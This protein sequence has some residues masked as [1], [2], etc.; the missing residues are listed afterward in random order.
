MELHQLRYFVAIADLGSMSR[1]ALLCRVAQPSISQ[2][3]QKLE[4]ELR[5]PLF[6]R[7]G[8]RLQL[9]DAGRSL[10]PKARAIL[11]QIEGI[12]QTLGDEDGAGH[13]RLVIGA[14]PTLAPYLLPQVIQQFAVS[15]PAAQLFVRE[16]LTE[17]L[18]DAVLDGELDFAITSTPIQREGLRA[19]IFAYDRF[20]IAVAH[21]HAL[22]GRESVSLAELV[23]LPTILLDELHCLGRQIGEVCRA[24]STNSRVVCQAS[25]LDLL[26]R[27]VEI[28]LGVAIVPALAAQDVGE[29]RI[30]FLA[31]EETFAGRELAIVRRSGRKATRLAAELM[32]RLEARGESIERSV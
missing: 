14:I 3:I 6:E 1:A 25:Q 28:G 32:Q 31:I 5:C 30:R 26:L 18:L 15:F 12:P 27:M 29:R 10:L 19:S 4:R 13:G 21:D 11:E 9:T 2:Q 7:L 8:R 23:S 17:R 20:V 24:M 16:D 22:A